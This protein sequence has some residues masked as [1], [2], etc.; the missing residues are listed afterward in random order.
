MKSVLLFCCFL[1]TSFSL[2]ATQAQPNQ[3]PV[4]GSSTQVIVVTTSDWNA[5][6]GRLQLYQRSGLGDP[7]SAVGEPITVVVGRNGMGWGDGILQIP[8]ARNTD[9]PVKRE[10]DGKAPAGI[11]RLGTA[12]GYA[13]QKPDGWKMPYLALTPNIDCVDDSRSRFYNRVIDR[14]TVAVDWNS[15]EHMR[16]AGEAYRWGVVID[17]NADSPRPQGGS[18][19]FMHIW[20]GPGVGTAGC[21]A[22][23]EPRIKFI[24]G[25]LNPAAKP[26]LVQ[27]PIKQY[28]RLEKTLRLPPPPSDS[29]S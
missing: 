1:A 9:E 26:L 23:P 5:V 22:M 11:F 14:S 13:A 25:W 8:I 12:F 7:W 6:D 16:S 3:Q 28:R 21:T 20:G 10:G 27:L 19:V 2:N 18:C 29:H 4:L 17:H 24:L 15:A